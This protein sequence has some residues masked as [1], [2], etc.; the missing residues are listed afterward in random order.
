MKYMNP[1]HNFF[2]P[3]GGDKRDHMFLAPTRSTWMSLFFISLDIWHQVQH[4]QKVANTQSRQMVSC[5]GH[6]KF[7]HPSN[8]TIILIS[9]HISVTEWKIKSNKSR[10]FGPWLACMCLKDTTNNNSYSALT[11]AFFLIVHCLNSSDKD[12]SRCLWP[13]F[14][15]VALPHGDP[16]GQGDGRDNADVQQGET[17]TLAVLLGG[18]TGETGEAPEGKAT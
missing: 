6:T 11:N 8:Y 5:S 4:G 17:K 7:N 15:A 18:Y 3:L 2:F 16:H 14:D 9:P 10:R 12:C 13:Y 1:N